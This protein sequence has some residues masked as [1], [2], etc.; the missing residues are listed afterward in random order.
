MHLLLPEGR[1]GII[2]E[3]LEHYSFLFFSVINV[4]IVTIVFAFLLAP[5]S[6]FVL[7]KVAHFFWQVMA[8]ICMV[9]GLRFRVLL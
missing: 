9:P 5:L 8:H 7:Q 3:P 2:W 4:V 1:E 6:C